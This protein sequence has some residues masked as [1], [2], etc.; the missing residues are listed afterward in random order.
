MYYRLYPSKGN[1]IFEQYS[2]NTDTPLDWSQSVN[3]GQM[4]VMQ[5]MDG[6]AY[7]KVLLG[8]DMPDWLRTKL[9]NNLFE[10]NLKIYDAGAKY[11]SL[12]PMKELKLEYFTDDFSEGAGWHFNEA[13]STPGISNWIYN[14]EN[15]LWSDVTFT[16]VATKFLNVN[17]EDLTFDVSSAIRESVENTQP[18]NFSLSTVNP[19]LDMNILIKFFWGR[20]T[21]TVFKPYLE[22]FI[23]DEIVDSSFN[24]MAGVINKVYFVNENGT[25]F[26][27]TL[28]AS[29]TLNDNSTSTVSSTNLGNGVYYI[30]VIPIE[31]R[32]INKKEYVS[33]TW[34]IGTQG[35]Y[36]QILDVKPQNQFISDTSYRNIMFYPSTPYT[37]NIVRQGDIIPFELIS[38]VRGQNDV[39]LD[40]YEYRIVSQ[41]GFEMCPW[42]QV[43]VYRNRMYF[44]VNTSY[45]YPEMQYEVFV[46][47]RTDNYCITSNTTHK[48]KLTAND[49][50]HLRELSATPYFVRESFFSK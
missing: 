43:S 20:H 16:E 9:T 11:D 2:P 32:R 4:T 24:M 37:H 10:C 6:A 26:T 15:S 31:P 40:S 22:F 44:F 1:T 34:I 38:Q 46:R 36:K 17:H 5:L 3:T 27:D 41:D 49:A 30:E 33:I 47:N 48:F 19:Q 35:V 23:H 14:L 12:L 25:D 42:T 50:S 29:I 13:N 45:F 21:K 39:V 8:F 7:S 28:T 18:A